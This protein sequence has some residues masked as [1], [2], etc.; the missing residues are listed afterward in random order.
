MLDRQPLAEAV[1]EGFEAGHVVGI[2]RFRGGGRV[3]ED[4]GV[5]VVGERLRIR[6]SF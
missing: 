2:R 4:A 6:R 3:G 5:E 1:E